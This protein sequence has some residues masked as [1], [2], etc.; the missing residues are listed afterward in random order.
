MSG[1]RERVYVRANGRLQIQRDKRETEYVW[2]FCGALE[3]GNDYM[4]NMFLG[5]SSPPLEGGERNEPYY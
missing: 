2:Y 1:E 4:G 5:F 3:E